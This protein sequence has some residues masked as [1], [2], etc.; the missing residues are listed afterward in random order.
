MIDRQDRQWGPAEGWSVVALV[1]ILGLIVATAIDEPAW[2]NG[3]GYLTDGLATCALLG[4]MVGFM[5]PKLG[6]GR[7]RT[8]VV[9]AL[10]AGLLIPVLA[11]WAVQ[12]GIP[13]ADAFR[14]T[15]HGT[16][17]AYLDLT[18]RGRQ[19]TTQEVHYV[20]VL[21]GL[22]WGTL[23]F[24]SFAVFGHRRPFSAVV[25]VGLVLLV[26]MALTRR[27]QLGWLVL[28]TGASL[29]LLIQMHAVDERATWLRRRIGEPS[30]VSSLYLRGGTI[31]VVAAMAGSLVLTTRAASSP[32]AGAWS[33]LDTQLV[34]VGETIGR[35]FPVGGDLRG[36]GGVAFGASARISLQWFSDAGVAFTASVPSTAADVPWRAATYDS[37]VLSGWEQTDLRT[38]SVAAGDPLLDASAENPSP[39]LT[40]A[41]QVTV[42]PDGYHDTK[43]LSLGLPTAVNIPSTV[44]L[45]GS[46]G[47]FAGVDIPGNASYSADAAVLKLDDPAGVTANRL[48]AA[49]QD[50][51][52]EILAR[53]TA[54]PPG[55]VGPDAQSLLDTLV[56]LAPSRNPYDL[57]KAMQD[58]LR[59]SR[60]TYT[61]DIRGVTCD[62]P[63]A[64]ECFARTREGYCLH[65]ASTM[66]ILLRAAYPDRPIPTRLVQGFLPGTLIGTT[67]TVLNR[68]AHAWVEVYFPDYG[69]IPFDPTGGGVGRPSEIK[70]GPP[71]APAT[72]TLG[73]PG[74]LRSAPVPSRRVGQDLPGVPGRSSGGTG[75]PQQPSD[76]TLLIVL[77]GLLAVA[78]G[79][80]IAMAWW[81]GPRGE[82]TPEG[83]WSAVGRAASRF[84]FAPRPTQ[85]VYEYASSLGDLVPVARPDLRTVADAK[86]EVA[87]ARAELE[88]ERASAV[89]AAMR[90][91]RVS[92]LRLA[93]LRV[94]RRRRG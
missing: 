32:L 54:V 46:Q 9:G 12:P 57:A 11:G 1:A 55:A 52:A 64:V 34:Q 40:T 60:F 61:T 84:G 76:S 41:M 80:L 33:G 6:W 2:V 75:G 4:A 69:W 74:S 71:V 24:G 82:V 48:R 93:V 56:K 65:Y 58:Y 29:F 15:A 53:Y 94:G 62:S 50:Y 44:D 63:S 38:T 31:F 67:E 88:P 81:R 43:L 5:G 77:T 35:L 86:V 17:E 23:Q 26:N 47:W 30:S 89:R 90:R 8:H 45:T 16:V 70:D 39:D 78:M 28:Y 18:V 27:D 73:P 10:F 85:T 68:N 79:G 72:P 51:P 7:W 66:A 49:S 37:F 42:N 87:Y 14:V 20:L 59:S 19:F 91:L 21:A 13:V 83:A 3:R 25:V 36:G 22:V 92:M